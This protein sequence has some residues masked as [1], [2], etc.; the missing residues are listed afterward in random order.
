[1]NARDKIA[2]TTLTEDL[3]ALEADA[4]T[5]K[6]ITN[7]AKQY[8]GFIDKIIAGESVH[9]YVLNA[10]TGQIFN[11]MLALKKLQAKG[12]KTEEEDSFTA[13]MSGLNNR[14]KKN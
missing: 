12:K 11:E 8:N 7:L 6:L 4:T 9:P 1:M 13:F 10:T 5:I 3:K 2:I 14:S